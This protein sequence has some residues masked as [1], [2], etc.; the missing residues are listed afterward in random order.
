MNLSR[1]KLSKIANTKYQSR[2]NRPSKK[3]NA[4][5]SKIRTKFTKKRK[6]G[7]KGKNLRKNTMKQKIQFNKKG[8]D[9]TKDELETKLKEATVLLNDKENILNT[10]ESLVT[11]S[12]E[13][14]KAAQQASEAAGSGETKKIREQNRN[15]AQHELDNATT[16]RE[17]A[18]REVDN[19]KLK[20]EEAQKAIE[21]ATTQA[22]LATTGAATTE[23][24]KPSYTFC[25]TGELEV[26]E[27]Y[28]QNLHNYGSTPEERCSMH[29]PDKYSAQQSTQ[30]APGPVA[31]ETALALAPAPG[32]AS[33][34]Q[35]GDN[36][37]KVILD[38]GVDDKGDIKLLGAESTITGK[39]DTSG[40]ST[41][42]TLDQGKQKF[43]SDIKNKPIDDMLKQIV[44]MLN[45]MKK[46]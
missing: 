45:D 5:A 37:F 34:E 30:A 24:T 31:P 4:G 9:P 8:G 6:I 44:E 38:M 1:N 11:R 14:L 26:D 33:N 7:G 21:A 27:K 18:E 36:R 23:Q 20:V 10:T 39:I 3:K 35:T 29:Y 2:K 42:V 12:N 41:I 15:K 46:Q 17:D 28:N 32:P 16:T 25:K 19:A 22:G 13:K 40:V 43:D